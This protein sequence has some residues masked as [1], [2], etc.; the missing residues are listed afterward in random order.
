MPFLRPLTHTD[1]L[2]CTKLSSATQMPL[3]RLIHHT[4]PV[5]KLVESG[6]NRIVKLARQ[7]LGIREI[8][9]LEGCAEDE[10]WNRRTN[11]ARIKIN[12]EFD[13]RAARREVRVLKGKYPFQVPL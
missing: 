5:S 10:R 4:H 3:N 6:R 12:W 8:A 13:R 1:R 11:R 7:C 9:D 2:A